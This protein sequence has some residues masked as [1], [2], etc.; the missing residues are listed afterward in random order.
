MGMLMATALFTASC[1]DSFL[2]EESKTQ[3]SVDE[4]YLDSL[5]LSQSLVAAYSPMEWNDWNG[6]QYNPQNIMSDIMADDIW[7]GGASV[8][9]NHY[10]HLMANY[11]ALATDCMTGIWS[12]CYSGIKRSNDVLS[13]IENALNNGLDVPQSTLDNWEAQAHLLRDYYYLLLWKFYG[14]IPYYEKN[15]TSD[16][17]YDQLPADSVY[18][19]VITD[20]ENNVIAKNALPMYDE[21]SDYGRVNQA[22]AYMI[23]AEMVMYQNDESRY[24]TALQ[25]MRNIINNG[26]FAL[27]S[28]YNHLFTSDGEW[29]TES[30]FEV[31]YTD[32]KSNRG[33]GSSDAILAGGTVLPRVISCP[34]GV[35][36][37]GMD[38]GW[39]FAPVRTSTYE[40]YADNDTRRDMSALDVR[41]YNEAKSDF[42]PRYQNTGFWLGKYVAYSTNVER[43]TGDKQLN[44]NN[45][46]RVYRYAETL[47]NAA[48]LIVRTNGDLTEAKKY[49]NEVRQR[50]GLLTEVEP[51][52]DNIINERHLE[53]VGEG[54]RYWDLVRTGKASSVLVPDEYGYR[55]NTWNENKKY[56]PIPY[57]EIAADPSLQQN[58][59]YLQ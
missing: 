21:E 7:V 52:I 22:M 27:D 59:A 50:A 35:S 45:N 53:F 26:H 33:W 14:N 4:Y 25:Y 32:Y 42:K 48:E 10:W 8:M 41:A 38:D 37:I 6:S 9:D 31:N 17:H 36:E 56:L 44:Y 3:Q 30:I 43:A 58:D 15:S 34:G 29:G 2:E 57:T 16:Y 51:T 55:T 47:L 12:N 18:N 40:M 23:Y 20:L 11:S 28:D 46:L 19:R 39:G 1:S 54:K 5:H 24:S 13:Y 49:L